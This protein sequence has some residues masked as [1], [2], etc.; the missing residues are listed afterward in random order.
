MISS[1]KT[2]ENAIS[3][4]GENPCKNFKPEQ[5]KTSS[6]AVNSEAFMERPLPF[7]IDEPSV[8]MQLS[9]KLSSNSFRH[10]SWPLNGKKPLKDLHT[11]SAFS[12]DVPGK[13]NQ[14]HAKSMKKNK[15]L[16]QQKFP[17]TR[18]SGMR[19]PTKTRS[20]ENHIDPLTLQVS[21]C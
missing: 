2:I 9:S 16:S 20:M 8:A 11:F 18:T 12:K 4:C 19:Q 7:L 6:Q 21:R 3:S 14:L 5:P 17:R 13:E 1:K 10:S 15:Q